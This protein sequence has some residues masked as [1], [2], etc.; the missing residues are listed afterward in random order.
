MATDL[1]RLVVQLS[2][3]IKGYENAMNRAQ[4]ITN[5]SV[6][7]IQNQFARSNKALTS[8]F[9]LLSRSFG[10][11]F[12]GGVSLRGAQQL[13]DTSTRIENALKLTGLSG[14]ELKSVYDQLFETAQRNAAPVEALVTLYSRMAVAQK[15]LNATQGELLQFTDL[16]GMSLRA[17][18]Q[19]ASEASGALLQLGQ[20]LGGGKV[21]AEEYNSL[22]DGARPLLQ[23]VAAG[24]E[25]AGGSV[26]RLT[27]LVKDGQVSSEAFFRAGQAGADVLREQLA[28][29]ELT[30]SQAFVRLQN[31]LIDTAGEIDEGS[32]AS[33]RLVSAL[34]TLAG[35]IQNTDFSPLINGVLNFGGAVVQ[36]I[37][38]IEALARAAGQL[39]GADNVGKFIYGKLDQKN[40]QDRINAAHSG[41]VAEKGDRVS[42]GGEPMRV[43]VTQ[44]KKQTVSLRDYAV[45]AA[46]K[47]GGG[48]RSRGGHGGGAGRPDELAREIEQIKERTAATLAETKALAGINPL[49]NDYG[50]AVE[51]ARAEQ[52]LL[53][54][55]K[56]AGKEVT[57]Q[58]RSEIGA[59]AE[60]YAFAASEADKLAAS[61]D[62]IRDAAEDAAAFNKDLLR[63]MVDG[64]IEGKKAA[65]IFADALSNIGNRLLDMAFDSAFST[66]GSGGFLANLLGGLGGLFG[67]AK[68]DPWGGLRLAGGGHVSGPGTATS[69]SIPAMLSDG[70]FVVRSSVA[71][72]HRRLLE[73]LNSGAMAGFAQGGAVSSSMPMMTRIPRVS[74]VGGG[75]MTVDARTT[76]DARGASVDAVLKLE[77][78][79]AKRDAELPSRIKQVVSRRENE[80]W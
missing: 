79:M 65:D 37:G 9:S 57:P 56:K 14:T 22:L 39:T 71:K 33:E 60:Q 74:K 21:Q 15:E 66:Q 67:G 61:Q 69:D 36:T 30:V 35:V 19:S 48:G 11:V 23:A 25:E 77:K 2:A 54:A 78:M 40:I 6:R 18:G 62:K 75:A 5:K 41:T 68:A 80:R 26:S 64:F 49:I 12:A 76:I 1:E 34:D 38:Q 53:T 27:A 8:Q 20:A 16:V 24:L 52:D 73:S 3:D 47:S 59:L 44:G 42:A 70:E 46:A 13:I 72:K 63:G 4:G 28:G 29:A 58:L 10:A 50:F 7:N 17:S 32:S 55:A 31:V 45:P 43:E 51:K